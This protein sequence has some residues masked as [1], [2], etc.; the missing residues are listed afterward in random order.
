MF[1]PEKQPENLIYISLQNAAEYSEIYSQEYLSLRARQGKLKAIK[2]GRNWVTTKDWIDEYINS[3]K[4]VKANEFNGDAITKKGIEKLSPKEVVQTEV[5]NKNKAEE[6]AVEKIK[7]NKKEKESF[8]NSP[9]YKFIATASFSFACVILVLLFTFSVTSFSRLTS[10]KNKIFEKSLTIRNEIQD[11]VFK[12]VSDNL[13]LIINFSDNS[14]AQIGASKNN[15]SSGIKYY[16]SKA[17]FFTNDFKG[18]VIE[19][20]LSFSSVTKSVAQEFVLKS[21]DRLEGFFKDSLQIFCDNTKQILAFS[22]NSGEYLLGRS[23]K[24]KNITLVFYESPG[25]FGKEILQGILKIQ[26]S[27]NDYA[28]GFPLFIKD[29]TIDRIVKIKNYFKNSKAFL[30]EIESA[31]SDSLKTNK[32]GLALELKDNIKYFFENAN[33]GAQKISKGINNAKDNLKALGFFIGKN[34]KAGAEFVVRPWTEKKEFFVENN[35]EEKQV[36]QNDTPQKQVVVKEVSTIIQTQPVKEITKETIISKIDSTELTN[37]KNQIAELQ[38]LANK[39]QYYSPSNNVPTSP[40]YIGSSGLEISGNASL[41][42]LGVSGFA[43]IRDLGVGNSFSVGGSGGSSLTVDKD[44]NLKA[45]SITGTSITGGSLSSTGNITATGNL[46]VSGDTA[47]ATTTIARLGIGTTTPYTT[48]DVLGD[49]RATTFYGDGSHLTGIAGGSGGDGNEWIFTGSAIYSTTSANY[50][51][52]STSTPY[53]TLDINGDMRLAGMFY[54]SS[55]SPGTMGQVL[56]ST[57]TSTR[58]MATSSL[59]TSDGGI[60]SLNGETGLTQYFASSTTGTDFTITHT[61][62]THTFNLPTASGTN[63]GLLSSSDWTYFNNKISTSSLSSTMTGLTYNNSTGVFSA[64]AN[65]SIPLTAST[66]EGSTAYTWGNHALAG[67]TTSTIYGNS[68]TTGSLY[69]GS[70]LQVVGSQT[71]GSTLNILATSTQATT[72]ITQLLVSGNSILSGGLW[73]SGVST[74]TTT[75]MSYL[76][77]SGNGTIGGK[78]GIGTTTPYTTLD[79]KGIVGQD[80]FRVASSSG[81]TFLSISQTGY[82]LAQIPDNSS[83]SMEIKEGTNSYLTFDTSNGAEKI[84]VG[85]NLEI[86]TMNVDEDSGAVNFVNMDITSAS[87][88]STVNSLSIALDGNSVLTAYGESAGHSGM[89]KNMRVG[90]GTTT[91]V[92]MLSIRGNVYSSGPLL[93][94][95]TSTTEA[96]F[97]SEVGLVGLSTSTPYVTLDINGDMRLAGMFYD[98]SGSPGTMGQ[99]L[100]STATSTRWM[101]T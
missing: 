98:G 73:T 99:V 80:P 47:L 100:W 34:V 4:N 7:S 31:V 44:G 69:I 37:L 6:I 16:F 9:A 60:T 66:T 48:L 56:W 58:W 21:K 52:I 22:K 3:E 101:A 93:R 65:Y 70:N 77:V 74:L 17:S 1:A 49:V 84:V 42:S 76:T 71:I 63:R 2:L 24:L 39:I 87:V 57:A 83:T 75:S 46:T 14:F 91:P 35:I 89:L 41:A 5:L 79:L 13:A 43:G 40:V 32:D 45:S 10:E 30:A 55:G 15:F 20:I 25:Y 12:Q 27:T 68:T 90:I 62:N 64:T 19:K 29:E 8:K 97:I 18:I 54:D 61:G 53:V 94:I 11:K 23:E 78:L 26:K 86:G 33:S 36:V 92:A 96:L 88:T 67:Y 81:A 82:L 72:S 51:G 50:V 95:S 38:N 59:G 28:V 85:K